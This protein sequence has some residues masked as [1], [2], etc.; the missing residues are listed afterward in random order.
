MQADK[1]LNVTGLSC[2]LPVVRSKKAIDEMVSG[3]VLEIH[4]TDKGAVKDIPAWAKSA[5]HVLLKQTE[6]EGVYKFWVQKG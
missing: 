3:Q 6:E 1:V 2:P 5:G 4:A